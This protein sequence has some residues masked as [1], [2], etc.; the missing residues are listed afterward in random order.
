M[1]TKAKRDWIDKAMCLAYRFAPEPFAERISLA[2]S[3]RRCERD[4]RAQTSAHLAAGGV[5]ASYKSN[6]GTQ[7]FLL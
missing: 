2:I 6:A 5:V 7:E 1:A 4:W 3:Q